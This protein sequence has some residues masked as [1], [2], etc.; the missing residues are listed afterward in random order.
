MNKDKDKSVH[1]NNF[2]KIPQTWQNALLDIM[3]TTFQNQTRSKSFFRRKRA[4]K[5]IGSSLEAE[6][7]ITAG[8][9]NFQILEGLDLAEYFI[10]SKAEKIESK[11]DLDLKIEVKKTAG[12]KCPR[13]W[14]ILNS[15]CVR[16]EEVT[17]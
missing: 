5:E 17:K 14:K 13:C 12:I 2:V 3:E 8:S 7:K 4:S 9:K 11:K 10:T 15:K 6:L 1:E 16:C